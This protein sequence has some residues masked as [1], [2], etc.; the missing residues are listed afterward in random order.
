MSNFYG[1]DKIRVTPIIRD[2]GTGSVT[3]GTPFSINAMVED[4]SSTRK[5]ESY[6][7]IDSDMYIFIQGNVESI[8]IKTGDYLEVIER[9]G[10]VQAN[11]KEYIVQQASS[12]GGFKKESM[13]VFV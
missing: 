9:F 10:V 8:T 3:R 4:I 11:P 6:R 12:F 5:I 1:R 2:S 13:E 7:E